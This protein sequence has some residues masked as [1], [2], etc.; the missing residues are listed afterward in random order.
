MVLTSLLIPLLNF[1]KRCE[2]THPV[3]PS[4]PASLPPLWVQG[5][6]GSDWVRAQ[7]SSGWKPWD[8]FKL[9]EPDPHCDKA[10]LAAGSRLGQGEMARMKTEVEQVQVEQNP[11]GGGKALTA[12]HL[13]C[14]HPSPERR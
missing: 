6:R 7:P 3:L 1:G 5:L 8:G 10:T 14:E 9:R 12:G 11:Q 13:S 4:I 2:A